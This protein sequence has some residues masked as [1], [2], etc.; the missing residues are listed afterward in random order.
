LTK[1]AA[2]D[3]I[4]FADLARLKDRDIQVVLRAVDHR[5][6]VMALC[7]AT[8]DVYERLLSNMSV[9]VRDSLAA[10]VTLG[11]FSARKIA[12]VHMAIARQAKHLADS[13]KI[14]LPE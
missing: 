9:R 6:L 14:S 7:G 10:E 8:D 1:Q 2:S 5:S 3:G 11:D 12:D 4:G 13:G